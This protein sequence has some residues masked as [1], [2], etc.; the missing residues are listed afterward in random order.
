MAESIENRLKQLIVESLMLE[1]VVPGEI[2]DEAPLFGEGLGLDSIDA[3]ELAL[4]I[5]KEFGV[6]T[7]ADDERNREI[8][9]SVRSLSDFIRTEQENPSIPAANVEHQA[10]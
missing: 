8:F 1:D 2:E 10:R 5:H 6:R 3:L 4:A 7:S 9:Y